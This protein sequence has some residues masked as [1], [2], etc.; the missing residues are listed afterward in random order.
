M[1][2]ARRH[3]KKENSAV[4]LS[5]KTEDQLSRIDVFKKMCRMLE[6][7]RRV[8]LDAAW[9]EY[10]LEALWREDCCCPP[11]PG[12]KCSYWLLIAQKEAR[13]GSL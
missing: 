2:T 10:Y 13:Y 5:G 11:L 6:V 1:M 9:R 4:P 12:G 7:R 8:V 3:H